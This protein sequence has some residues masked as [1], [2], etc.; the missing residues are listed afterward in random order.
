MLLLG[1]LLLCL[2]PRALMAWKLDGVCPDGVAYIH[3]AKLLDQGQGGEFL[4]LAG[5]NPLPMVL[6][7]LHRAGLDWDTGRESLERAH[8][9]RGRVAAVRLAAAA[10]RPARGPGRLFPLRGP[11]RD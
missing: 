11:Q 5:L 6:V 7:V 2:A 4:R 10:V 8:G 3:L 9:R 1:L